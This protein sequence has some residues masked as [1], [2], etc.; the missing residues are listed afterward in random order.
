MS[1][2]QGYVGNANAELVS[3]EEN[4]FTSKK[5]IEYVTYKVHFLIKQ[6]WDN[7][8]EE[9]VDYADDDFNAESYHIKP[10]YLLWLNPEVGEGKKMSSMEVSVNTIENAFDMEIKTAKDFSVEELTKNLAGKMCRIKCKKGDNEAYT[11]VEALYNID[12]KPQAR[13]A[14][15]EEAT[16]VTSALDSYF[17]TR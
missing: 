4:V 6:I 9:Y 12:Y 10:N 17:G 15:G 5:D 2:K 3:F 14:T 8:T 11:E 1:E 13:K 16:A 7:V